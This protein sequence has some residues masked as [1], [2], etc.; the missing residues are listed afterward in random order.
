MGLA[1]CILFAVIATWITV[2]VWV[3]WRPKSLAVFFTM[4]ILSGCLGCLVGVIA[5]WGDIEKFN[6]IS[7]FISIITVVPVAF[8]I[9]RFGPAGVPDKTVTKAS[10]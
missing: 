4:G 7:V 3:K 9:S 8:F 10:I 6:L 1:T 2:S 5:G